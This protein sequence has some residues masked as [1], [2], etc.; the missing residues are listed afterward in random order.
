MRETQEHYILYPKKNGFQGFVD[1]IINDI[2]MKYCEIKKN[3]KKSEVVI[4]P[5]TKKIQN[6]KLDG[7]TISAD[8]YFWCNSPISLSRILN[9]NLKIEKQ[10][11]PQK[12][13]F[14]N[15]VFNKEIKVNF[16]EILVG[17][18]EHKINR[19]SFPGKIA[20][21]KNNLVQVEFSFPENQYS[22]D[23]TYWKPT[24][25]ESLKKVGIV[26]SKNTLKSFSIISETRGMISKLELE[27]MKE[28][29]E[30]KIL[31]VKGS[32]IV[33]PS[34]NFG[35]ENINRVV[36]QVILNT[37]ESIVSLTGNSK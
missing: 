37:V 17:S 20:N 24:W 2:D 16:H 13:I 21:K 7:K 31:S 29:Y 25:L 26:Q 33:I 1:A 32:N 18:L 34:F 3:I 4:H 19:I 5:K 15:F 27:H 23:K 6:I 30:S 36:P 28:L 12:I 14:G 22:L 8:L 10:L 35:P 9:I 11:K